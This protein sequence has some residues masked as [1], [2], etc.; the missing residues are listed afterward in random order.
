MNG[1]R[2]QRYAG[3]TLFAAFAIC[4]PALADTGFLNR[5]V[6]LSK[7]SHRYQVFVPSD[8]TPKRTWP[9]IV[10][11]HGNGAQ[12]T[13]GIRQ[14]AHFLPDKIRLAS[15]AFPVIVVFPQA[16][17][18]TT[19]TTPEMQELVIAELNAT[20]AEFKGDERRVYLTGF[21][22]GGTGVYSI[23]SRW[24]ER[25]AG[26]VAIAGT[27]PIQADILAVSISRLPCWIFH[28]TDDERVSVALARTL[29]AAFKNVGAPVR[30]TEY[31]DTDH[32]SSAD[33]AYA[34]PDFVPW[35]LAQQRWVPIS[36][37]PINY[38]T[39]QLS[40]YPI[41]WLRTPGRG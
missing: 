36:N 19:W 4:P 28:G 24:P 32:G 30:F 31:Q 21:S 17:I 6:T 23:A 14:T 9:V 7:Q 2:L 35:L 26:L 38:P 13:D 22:M 29:A 41:D 18:G 3:L 40:N 37:P 10:D 34:E 27:P 25:F 5:A 20:M 8:Y 11:L 15:T 39:I 12:G 16:A 1:V 33:K